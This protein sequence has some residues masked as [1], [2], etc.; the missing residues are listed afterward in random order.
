[1]LKVKG[2]WIFAESH[3]AVGGRLTFASADWFPPHKR[4]CIDLA[5]R[6]SG[7]SDF[8]ANQSGQ[9][10]YAQA[11]FNFMAWRDRSSMRLLPTEN[12]EAFLPTPPISFFWTRKGSRPWMRWRHR[13]G[14]RVSVADVCRP[15][16]SWSD[17][18][19]VSLWSCDK[20]RGIK[21][22]AKS[23]ARKARYLILAASRLFISPITGDRTGWM[24]AW[25]FWAQ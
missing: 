25:H 24:W 4:I 12:E 11:E 3:H 13:C 19:C 15:D 22:K 14:R 9:N 10:T 20:I 6:P 23:K 16:F 7:I 1:M 18:T 21:E 8:S 5:C 2:C 17:A